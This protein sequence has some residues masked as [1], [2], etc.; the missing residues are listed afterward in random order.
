MDWTGLISNVLNNILGVSRMTVCSSP[1][2]E[3]L[4]LLS[5]KEGNFSSGEKESES[6]GRGGL[7]LGSCQAVFFFLPHCFSLVGSESHDHDFCC[8]PV[9]DSAT[10]LSVVSSQTIT[11]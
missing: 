3:A 6:E 2:L 11:P 8:P 10:W 4:R 7:K 1:D 9:V 5:G